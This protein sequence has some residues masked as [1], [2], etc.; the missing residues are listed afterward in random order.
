MQVAMLMSTKADM[1]TS[2][3]NH[4]RRFRSAGGRG[5]STDGS[6]NSGSEIARGV[7]TVILTCRWRY[8]P[9]FGLYPKHGL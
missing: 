2:L 7:V 8:F 9:R 4:T 3:T 6:G 5:F 1:I